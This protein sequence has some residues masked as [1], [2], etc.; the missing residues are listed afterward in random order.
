MTRLSW[1]LAATLLVAATRADA[2]GRG[3]APSAGTA[4]DAGLAVDR[5]LAE[6]IVAE[7]I[8]P[9]DRPVLAPA[10]GGLLGWLLPQ[11]YLWYPS[12]DGEMGEVGVEVLRLDEDLGLSESE[13]SV[14][15]ALQISL[16]NWGFRF[17][18]FTLDFT[19]SNRIERD[20]EFGGISFPINEQVDSRIRLDNYRLVALRSI[21]RTGSFLLALQGGVSWYDFEGTI[22]SQTL[23]TGSES[24]D[25]PIPVVGALL[26]ARV[27][28]FLLE[29][30]VSGMS[31]RVGGVDADLLE[32][33]ASI[34][35]QLFRI[36]SLR[37][38]YRMVEVRG[39]ASGFFVDATID[40]FFL[41]ASLNF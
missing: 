15:P 9:V 5:L 25:V 24:G 41:G 20:F 10:A 3:D 29:V 22:T 19:G 1:I 12:I 27:G 31:I 16:G 14:L 33:Q 36:V 7:W 23:G 17:S 39:E 30:D 37:G 26:Q 21:V 34:G 35:I 40:G 32:V 4:R 18:A 38:G 11:I 13:L 8:P 28:R 2:W 6:G